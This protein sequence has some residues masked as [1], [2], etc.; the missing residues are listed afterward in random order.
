M[1]VMTNNYNLID[2]ILNHSKSKNW[3]NAVLEWNIVGFAED[4]NHSSKCICGK[5]NIKYLYDIKNEYNSN[6]SVVAVIPIAKHKEEEGRRLASF[7]LFR[8]LK[9]TGFLLDKGN[10]V[11]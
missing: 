3:N 4:R 2:V 7:F 6:L 1:D 9:C 8:L 11:I 5:E 10:T